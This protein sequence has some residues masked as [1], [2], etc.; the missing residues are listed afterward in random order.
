MINQRG[1]LMDNLISIMENFLKY[2][3]QFFMM[4]LE[5][6]GG[7]VIVYGCFYVFYMFF[8][9]S[10]E[11]STK[12]RVK[13]GRITSLALEF[14]LGAEILRTV[15]IREVEELYVIA[16]IVILRIIMAFVIHKEMDMDLEELKQENQHN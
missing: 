14:Y 16:S 2:F 12:I 3:S 6:L 5:F 15:F 8:F 1:F 4:V 13:L 11:T 9:S 7:I 10:K